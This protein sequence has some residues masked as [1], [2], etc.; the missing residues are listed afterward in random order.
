MLSY[1]M[2]YLPDRYDHHQRL[3][4]YVLS[5]V[6]DDVPSIRDAALEC[7]EKCGLQHECEHP[8][9]VIE[10]RQFGIDGDND[11]DY[12]RDL[13]SPFPRRPSLGARLFVRTNASRFFLA[14][15][16][17][18]SS[19]REHSRIRSAELL[20]ILTVYCEEHM[21]KDFSHTIASIAKAI[22]VELSS[23]GEGDATGKLK[24]IRRVLRLMGKYVDPAAY[25]PLLC[26]RIS[27][28]SSS[29]TS[30]S[31]DGCHSECA[32]RNFTIVLSSLIGGSPVSRLVLHWSALAN[33]LS[34]ADCIGPF[35]GTQ[36]RHQCLITLNELI[37]AVTSEDR[38]V[39][40]ASHLGNAGELGAA[41]KEIMTNSPRG[42]DEDAEFSKRC[43][44]GLMEIKAAIEGDN[45]KRHVNL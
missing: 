10:R 9:D 20:L 37:V 18:L 42:D 1:F 21:T 5:F 4:P 2:V 11:I 22:G 33:L 34:S 38:A 8:Q 39:S 31:E 44:D 29:G 40:F 43:I 27:S 23:R 35:V 19:W 25:L 30:D 7:I 17:E 28:D 16:G 13:P 41:M 3:L 15:L 14:L 26:P 32:R 36:T 45:M 24:P 12:D 6:N